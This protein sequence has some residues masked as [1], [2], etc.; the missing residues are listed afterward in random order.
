MVKGKSVV[1]PPSSEEVHT[2]N[3]EARQE[4][5]LTIAKICHRHGTYL[6]LQKLSFHCL[7]VSKGLPIIAAQDRGFRISRRLVDNISALAIGYIEEM[8]RDME[9]FARHARRSTIQVED[10][11]LVETSPCCQYYFCYLE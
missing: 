11:K 5:E 3:E 9:M 6:A 10:V 7:L 4:M 2:S 8:Q 1:E